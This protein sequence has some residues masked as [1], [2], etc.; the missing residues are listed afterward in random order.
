MAFVIIW[1]SSLWSDIKLEY[2]A[3]VCAFSF[4]I[5]IMY[6]V[7]IVLSHQKSHLFTWETQNFENRFLRWYIRLTYLFPSFTK[8]FRD[9]SRACT[10]YYDVFQPLRWL[11]LQ[12]LHAQ[13]QVF[14][15]INSKQFLLEVGEPGGDRKEQTTLEIF[16][17]EYDCIFHIQRDT[18]VSV[19]LLILF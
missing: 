9:F 6:V 5:I 10:W 1:S 14:L 12:T 3:S 17:Y 18:C 8:P 15:Y 11:R 13:I 7:T 16:R 2:A 4:L 19:K